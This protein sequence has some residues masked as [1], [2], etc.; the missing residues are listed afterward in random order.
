MPLMLMCVSISI[1][2]FQEGDQSQRDASEPWNGFRPCSRPRSRTQVWTAKCPCWC[3]S[4]PV[5]WWGTRGP[6]RHTEIHTA[7]TPIKQNIWVEKINLHYPVPVHSEIGS[8]A[9]TWQITDND[10]EPQTI[11]INRERL[12]RLRSCRWTDPSRRIRTRCRWDP[13]SDLSFSSSHCLPVYK[14]AIERLKKVN[15][16]IRCTQNQNM[17]SE[18]TV[19]RGYIK[20]E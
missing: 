7:T 14:T 20:K 2:L 13:A 3:R 17:C 5:W 10:N 16:S 19:L 18:W 1:S 6:A 9:T 4:L 12:S 8:G 15:T 11:M